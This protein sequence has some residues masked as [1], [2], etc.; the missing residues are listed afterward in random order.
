MKYEIEANTERAISEQVIKYA[1]T[2][3]D[4]HKFIA[5]GFS[6]SDNKYKL[7]T[8]IPAGIYTLNHDEN[9]IEIEHKIWYDHGTKLESVFVRSDVSIEHI[10]S[11]LNTCR[12]HSLNHKNDK[13]TCRI[14]KKGYWGELSSLPKR[15]IDTVVLSKTEKEN[16]INDIETFINCEEEY[17]NK[18]IPY[19]RNY[20]LEGKPG[21]GKTSL[22]FAI[23]SHL[24]MDLCVMNF[25]AGL[26]DINFMDAVS[27]MNDN[28]ILVLEDI[29][30]IFGDRRD[31]SRCNISFGSILNTLDGIGRKH[32]LITFMTTNYVDRLDPA[33][34]RPGRIDYKITMDYST[35]DQ[36]K[37]MYKQIINN[38]NEKDENTFYKKIQNQ[39]FT[40]ALLQ[41]Y[42]F[43]YRNC[44]IDELIENIEEFT[45]LCDK[46]SQSN[47]NLYM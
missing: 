1:A 42:L 17:L 5:D 45:D 46:E 47:V 28:S 18:G 15:P 7:I 11:F 29:D 41:K 36:I 6:K 20:L 8:K 34:I 37:Y 35:K 40:T 19:K 2:Q 33:L 23:A 43:K 32:K 4:S 27:N 13:V 3:I 14:M 38:T 25:S 30:C 10:T 16:I 9:D 44:N 26:D 21:T 39:K 24:D 22:I 12:K 31:V